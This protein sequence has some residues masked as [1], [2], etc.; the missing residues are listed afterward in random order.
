M[1]LYLAVWEGPGTGF[2]KQ[3]WYGGT[4]IAIIPSTEYA[5]LRAMGV[6]VQPGCGYVAS[7]PFTLSPPDPGL[8]WRV[9]FLP[10]TSA[11]AVKGLEKS[12]GHGTER[13]D[14]GGL[15]GG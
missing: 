5:G 2:R 11:A 9:S 12:E 1:P 8:H 10:P 14:G 13:R 3:H 15:C 7:R 4:G 6:D